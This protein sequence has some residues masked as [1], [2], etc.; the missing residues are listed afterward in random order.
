[1]VPATQHQ[2]VED[3]G[4]TEPGGETVVE[5]VV[6]ACLVVQLVDTDDQE[7]VSLVAPAVVFRRAVDQ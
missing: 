5:S 6:E 2:Q 1:V 7:A 3:L 4:L